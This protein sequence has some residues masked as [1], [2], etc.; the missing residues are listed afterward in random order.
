MPV[1]VRPWW[2][3][4]HAGRVLC[5]AGWNLQFAPRVEARAL[6]DHVGGHRLPALALDARKAVAL[7]RFGRVPDRDSDHFASVGRIALV[8]AQHPFGE[9]A[10]SP[11]PAELLACARLQPARRDPDV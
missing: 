7:T 5:S 4:G 9:L 8:G 2:G 1:R 11:R 3:A 6:L 10:R